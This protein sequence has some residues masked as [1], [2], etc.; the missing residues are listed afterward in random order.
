MDAFRFFPELFA[1]RAEAMEV[2]ASAGFEWMTHYSSVDL[3]HELYGLEVCGIPDQ[4]DALRIRSLLMEHFWRWEFDRLVLKDW[5]DRDLGW[6]VV[7]HRDAE[8]AQGEWE[9]V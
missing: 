7:I 1:I 8:R 2:L 3:L 4:Q 9:T 5:G 6:K